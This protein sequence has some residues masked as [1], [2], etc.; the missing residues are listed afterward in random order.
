MLVSLITQCGHKEMLFDFTNN[1]FERF[2]QNTCSTC[3][4]YVFLPRL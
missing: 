1:T 2:Q 3:S 4:T